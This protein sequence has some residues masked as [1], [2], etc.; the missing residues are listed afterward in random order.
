MI[1]DF[2]LILGFLLCVRGSAK[3]HASNNHMIAFSFAI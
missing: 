3:K 1:F 2:E